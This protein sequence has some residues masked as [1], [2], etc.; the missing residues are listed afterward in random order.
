VLG[1]VPLSV[2]FHVGQP[3]HGIADTTGI[4]DHFARAI[5]DQPGE[6]QGQHSR[7]QMFRAARE[8]QIA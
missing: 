3:S 5:D 7:Y 2:K 8:A 6:E 4:P 1:E